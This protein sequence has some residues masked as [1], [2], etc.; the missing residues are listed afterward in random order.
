MCECD[1]RQVQI[2]DNNDHWCWIKEKPCTL[3]DGSFVDP[4]LLVLKCNI[5]GV[6]QIDCP[7]KENLDE[8][9]KM[10][11]NLYSLTIY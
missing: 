10:L 9:K 4:Q 6:P 2:D 5:S 7:G 11:L 1:E 8:C 3:L